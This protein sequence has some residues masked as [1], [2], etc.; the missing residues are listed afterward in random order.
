MQEVQAC[1]LDRS[2]STLGWACQGDL[3]SNSDT[4]ASSPFRHTLPLLLHHHH[5][6]LC[7]QT[8]SHPLFL[9]R[10]EINYVFIYVIVM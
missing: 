8:C 10:R 2:T 7:N 6:D 5:S 3:H 9:H 1:R 4:T